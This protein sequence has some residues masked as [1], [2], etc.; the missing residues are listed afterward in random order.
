MYQIL[1]EVSLSKYL[2]R[3]DCDYDPCDYNPR[4]KKLG[5]DHYVQIISY[6]ACKQT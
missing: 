6:V 4:E 1:G 3:M 2:N 5:K